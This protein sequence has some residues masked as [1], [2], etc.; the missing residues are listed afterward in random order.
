MLGVRDLLFE[1][2]SFF[3]QG[4]FC[5]LISWFSLKAIEVALFRAGLFFPGLGPF[6]KRAQAYYLQPYLVSREAGKP[7]LCLS[8]SRSRWKDKNVC[9]GID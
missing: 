5:I 1:V 4:L 2:G 9:Q 3:L 6:Q 7:F 8:D